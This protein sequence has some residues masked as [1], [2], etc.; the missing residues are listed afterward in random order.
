MTT[1]RS[2]HFRE[3][4]YLTH[5]AH[6]AHTIAQCKDR[7]GINMTTKRSLHF[8]EDW[9]GAYSAYNRTTVLENPLCWKM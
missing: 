6:T 3:D 8:R 2:L 4:W 1:K 7:L 5:T 9:Y